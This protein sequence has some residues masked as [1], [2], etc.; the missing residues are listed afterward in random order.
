MYTRVQATQALGSDCHL[1]GS[2]QCPLI[3]SL[4][5]GT[6]VNGVRASIVAAGDQAS[7]SIVV[8]ALLGAAH[9]AA[10]VS[11][12]WRAKV[13]KVAEVEALVDELLK[14]RFE[15]LDA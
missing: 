1:P 13:V 9:G 14:Q 8:G 2:F 5:G 3:A 10:G 11:Q 7:R 15:L 12:E 6:Y 4:Y